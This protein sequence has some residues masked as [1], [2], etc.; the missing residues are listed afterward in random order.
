MLRLVLSIWTLWRLCR[1]SGD[2]D[3][4]TEAGP[5]AAYEPLRG[6]RHASISE[7][8]WAEGEA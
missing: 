7:A 4:P 2:A 1:A 6:G 8:S 5:F 3:T